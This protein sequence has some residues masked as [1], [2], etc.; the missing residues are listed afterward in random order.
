MIDIKIKKIYG[1]LV[2]FD[3]IG[4]GNVLIDC[5]NGD[6]DSS[7]FK[8]YELADE[9]FY[10]YIKENLD[11]IIYNI[12]QPSYQRSMI[13]YYQ[14]SESF[15]NDEVQKQVEELDSTSKIII[16]DWVDYA[17]PFFIEYEEYEICDKITKLNNHIKLTFK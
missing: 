9:L 3:I 4:K 6:F 14:F 2:D 16:L 17:L 1:S 15:F 10:D 12:L 13:E 8:D 7:S 5:D 11:E